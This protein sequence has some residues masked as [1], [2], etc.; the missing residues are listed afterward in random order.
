M[1]SRPRSFAC[2]PA[3][4][5]CARLDQQRAVC[6]TA[7]EACS[8]GAAAACLLPLSCFVVGHLLLSYWQ[9]RTPVFADGGQPRRFGARPGPPGRSG[10]P[11]ASGTGQTRPTGSQSRAGAAG[12]AMQAP[13]K[14]RIRPS[15]RILAPP[16]ASGTSQRRGCARGPSCNQIRTRARARRRPTC[17]SFVGS[18]RDPWLR[19][20]PPVARIARAGPDKGNEDHG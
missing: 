11:A 4:H 2:A 17:G 3:P 14:L 13:K 5:S 19:N 7:A 15:T 1:F 20:G 12:A 8:S 18:D 9:V 6:P 10:N 16:P